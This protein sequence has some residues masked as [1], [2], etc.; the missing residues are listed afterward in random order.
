M[1]TLITNSSPL[2]EIGIK[3][4]SGYLAAKNV[5][6]KVIYLN[7]IVDNYISDE[8]KNALLKVAKG[9]SLIGLSLMTKDFFL[10]KEL[11]A[12]LKE[13]TKAR[14]IWGGIHPTVKPDEAI[15]FCDF[16]C[17]GEGEEPLY[18][19]TKKL[20]SNKFSDIP[21]IVYKKH[22]KILKNNVDFLIGN[23]D[24]LPLPDYEFK[25]SYILFEG[26]LIKIPKNL[27]TRGKVLGSVLAFYSQRGCP[28]S[29]TYCANYTLRNLYI[30]KGKLFYRRSSVKR[31]I[32]ELKVY[33]KM[34]PFI[35]E[36]IINDDEFLARSTEE[37]KEFSIAYKKEIDLPFSVNAIG[38]FVEEDKIKW[39]ADASLKG[40]ALGIQTGSNRVLKNIYNRS[41]FNKI[42]IKAS[43]VFSKYKHLDIS[44]DLILDNPYEFENDKIKTIKLINR[45]FRPFYLQLYTLIFFPGTKIYE[46]AK[47][48]GFIKDEESQIYRKRYQIDIGNGYLNSIFFLNSIWLLPKWLNDLLIS[49]TLCKNLFFLP[50]RFLMG[51]SIK[52]LLLIKGIKHIFHSP[53]LLKHYVK[54]LPV[55]HRF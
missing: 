50:F 31:I 6:C 22:N 4:L 32:E 2:A 34:M 48:D 18:L 7:N 47:K 39:L 52:F 44:Y 15:N 49:K 37:I 45:L 38:T 21:N 28:F 35:K 16:V 10:F 8:V 42:N 51:R 25:N 12:F 9:S 55:L 43:K 23:L 40:V 14:I 5:P 3:T 11:T 54:Y 19:L 20:K 46:M 33:K 27:T 17:V 1:V 24:T 26:K 29:C 53:R 13:N 41:V 30:K 36:I